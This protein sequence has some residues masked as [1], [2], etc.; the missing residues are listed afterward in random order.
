MAKI[1]YER[2]VKLIFH[3]PSKFPKDLRIFVSSG[4]NYVYVNDGHAQMHMSI[5]PIMKNLKQDRGDV[6]DA[7]AKFEFVVF[8]LLR[9]SI[10][11]LNVSNI[12]METIKALSPQQRINVL[13]NS[14]IIDSTLSKKLSE[15]LTLRN[16]FAHKFSASEVRYK[17]I[18]VFNK[19]NFNKLQNDLQGT[20]DLLI[21]EYAN[22]LS[23]LDLEPVIS[24]ITIMNPTLLE[25]K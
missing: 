17:E 13:K 3:K 2:L 23:G 7:L 22:T 8:E 1:L 10:S 14:Q 9:F 4:N 19:D 6:L 11:G 15:A 20:W 5:N 12:I 24:T 21:E 25:K 16:G 18:P